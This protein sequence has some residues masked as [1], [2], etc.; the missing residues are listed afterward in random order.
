MRLFRATDQSHD[1]HLITERESEYW[2]LT[3]GSTDVERVSELARAHDLSDSSLTEIVDGLLESAPKI[4]APEAQL[5]PILPEEVWA[6]GVTYEISEQAREA[7]SGM[8]DVYLDVFE[9]DRPELFLKA[10]PNRLVGPGEDVGIRADSSWDVPEPELGIVLWRGEIIGYTIGNDMSSRSI[11]GANPLYLP[12]AKVYDRCCSLGPTIT[13]PE[14]I[15][16]PHDLT[17]TMRIERDGSS[18]YEGTTTTAKMVRTCQELVSYLVRHNHLPAMTVL[19]TGT[20][21]VPPDSVTLDAGDQIEITIESIGT[22]SNTVTV[23]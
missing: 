15:G 20:S 21:L 17:M 12:Q 5:L 7:E 1:P 9:S 2:D 11:E 18:I 13:L 22:L 14:A 19:L 23:V 8:A 3:A 6:A 4:S 10:T 16:D